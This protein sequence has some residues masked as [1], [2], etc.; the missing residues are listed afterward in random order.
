MLRAA[1]IKKWKISLIIILCCFLSASAVGI[2]FPTA[3]GFSFDYSE[4]EIRDFITL[5]KG[6]E[7]KYYF[8]APKDGFTG[9]DI[10]IKQVKSERIF[11]V[12]ATLRELYK[13]TTVTQ[14]IICADKISEDEFLKLH[15]NP[16]IF[17]RG[18]EFELE[19]DAK[20]SE[21]NSFFELVVIES[22]DSIKNLPT[23]F[24]TS[25][26]D[27]SLSLRLHF[28]KPLFIWRLLLDNAFILLIFITILSIL[29]FR[30]LPDKYRYAWAIIYI[31]IFLMIPTYVIISRDDEGFLLVLLDA[32]LKTRTLAEGNF[33]FWNS[34][35]GIGMPYNAMASINWHPVWL[36]LDK[37]PLF[38]VVSILYHL[39]MLIAL[40]SMYWLGRL[41]GLRKPTA[42]VCALSYICSTYAIT[43]IFGKNFW[44][45]GMIPMTLI[46]LVLLVLIKF[47]YAD[48]P[49]ERLFYSLLT[50][51]CFG[52]FV[53]NCHLG[54]VL[55]FAICI[56]FYLFANWRRL[57]ERWPW[58]FLLGCLILLIAAGRLV[59][60]FEELRRFTNNENF[61]PHYVKLNYWGLI[62]WPIVKVERGLAFGAPFFLLSF[63]GILWLGLKSVH[64]KAFS[65]TI[66][67]CYAVS[68]IPIN[69]YLPANWGVNIFIILFSVLLAGLVVDQLWTNSHR[70]KRR[71]V[72]AICF[73]QA[74]IAVSGAIDYWSANFKRS[75]DYIQ[76]NN[77]KALKVAF[78]T[79]PI[80]RII[81]TYDK[82]QGGR[83]YFTHKAEKTLMRSLK[84][85]YHYES[86]PLKGFRILNGSWFHGIDYSDI[87]PNRAFLKGHLTGSKRITFNKPLL[88]VLGIRY[89]FADLNEPVPSG[90]VRSA[91]LPGKD[92]QIIVMYT[93]PNAWPDAVVVSN[94][95]SFL[96][97]LPERGQNI[98]GLLFYN[99]MPL[100]GERIMGDSVTTKRDHGSIMLML[101]PSR[102]RR[103]VMVS[104][105]FRPGWKAK[106]R[107]SEGF[108]ET[109]VF[110]IF[111]HLIGIEVPKG[112]DE[113][114]L[115]YAPYNKIIFLFISLGTL[116]LSAFGAIILL[117]RCFR[118]NHHI[119]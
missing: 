58:V 36:L 6:D 52:F 62:L 88:D 66:L 25:V 75:I 8:K 63:V 22:D 48:E 93:N 11:S 4:G 87:H 40:F 27:G 43:Y 77:V 59:D 67:G 32:I 41:I 45:S 107:S 91:L 2:Y 72:V 28:I 89:I 54:M 97:P 51:S 35:N 103:T 108:I 104:E 101:E 46:P 83:S 37:V 102:K 105:Y 74:F 26:L 3:E 116:I 109:S 71:A 68:L 65:I 80:T 84:F 73:L 55:I 19:I 98:K 86:I 24:N 44:P 113:I 106:W 5:K 14:E 15:F 1:F 31:S 81:E 7:L 110:P 90:L 49:R 39:H 79:S 60:L 85:G 61:F 47:L 117:L 111:G 13:Q 100:L 114:R 115:S 10:K 64:R 112:A 21:P 95:I 34:F 99:F 16:L 33:P 76:N 30:A 20:G 18:S 17:S 50:A 82:G 57:L 92:D 119:E 53:L 38:V 12:Q 70:F 29:V 23:I 42:F 94:E 9:L 118:Q 78:D 56:S 69:P 96:Q